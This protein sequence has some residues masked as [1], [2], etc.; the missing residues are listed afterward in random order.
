VVSDTHLTLVSG[1]GFRVGHLTPLEWGI[2]EMSESHLGQVL[3]FEN[4]L[5]LGCNPTHQNKNITLFAPFLFQLC[6]L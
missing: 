3:I 6:L 1:L 5:P 4:T 2:P